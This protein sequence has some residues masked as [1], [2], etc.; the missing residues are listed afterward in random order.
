[1]S[2]VIR[3]MSEPDLT[4]V[5]QIIRLAFG[6]FMGAPDPANWAADRDYGRVRFAIDP[7]AAFVAMDGD[8]LIGSNFG[9][10]WGSVA[11]FGPLTVHPEYWDKGV[12]QQLLEPVMRRFDEWDLTHAGLFT[13]SQSPKHHVLYQKFGFWPRFLISIFG[14]RI[15]SPPDAV[16]KRLS[17]ASGHEKECLLAGI[18]NVSEAIYAG[19][20]L[21]REIETAAGLGFG[22]TIAI[23]RD[24]V[25]VGF[26]VC[27]L[28]HGTEA[29][30][31][32]CYPKFAGVTPG[33]HAAED[34]ERLVDAIEHLAVDT[35]HPTVT[36]GVNQSRRNAYQAMLR[37]GYRIF[38]VGVAMHRP[39]EMG[40]STPDT[41]VID[42]WR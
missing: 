34:F 25:V 19:L 30:E 40:Y 11:F 10:C 39:D 41:Y 21:T 2:V 13:F 5:N 31:G 7:S 36:G 3:P 18:Q 35:G 26:A 23:Q 20:D 16:Y 22:D 32:M 4:A 29:G 24:G 42:D 9:T 38:A 27:H 37:R 6:T 1:M 15:E 14:K 12:G 17:I 28:G 8:R 33:E